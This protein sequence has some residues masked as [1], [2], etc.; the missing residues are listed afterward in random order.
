MGTLMNHNAT[1]SSGG[2]NWQRKNMAQEIACAGFQ[3]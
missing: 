1:W 2:C 3:S